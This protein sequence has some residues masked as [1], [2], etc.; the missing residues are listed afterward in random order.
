[1][2]REIKQKNKIDN[3]VQK[4]LGFVKSYYRIIGKKYGWHQFLGSNKIGNI[5]TAQA[6]L[7]FHYFQKDFSE[8]HRAITSIKQAQ[9]LN[10]NDKTLDGGWANVTNAST[11]PTT[12]CSGWILLL[13]LEE[14]INAGECL[15]KGIA[16][17]LANHPTEEKSDLGWSSI[18]YDES[19]LKYDEIRVYATALA[20]RVL[21]R[22][23]YT[24]TDQFIKA[25]HWLIMARNEQDGGWGE[26]KGSPSTFLHTAHAL[27]ALRECGIDPD[28]ETLSKGCDWLLNM[29]DPRNLWNDPI[30][31]GLMEYV[32]IY[33]P[34]IQRVTYLHFT[35]PWV[36]N[37][38]IMCGRINTIQVFRGINWIVENCHNGYWD[39]PY[40][41]SSKNKPMW[42]IYDSLLALKNFQ[43][44]FSHWSKIKQV[45]L[46]NG[47]ITIKPISKT[48]ISITQYFERLLKSK[49]TWVCVGVIL[50]VLFLIVFG[51]LPAREGILGVLVPFLIAI[52]ANLVTKESK[53]GKL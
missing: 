50:V 14:K 41:V 30:R 42:A 25:K 32:D 4:A 17:L 3:V 33:A 39:H 18:K 45:I 51:I 35:T 12:E 48:R 15:N 19:H 47:E 29:Y 44:T 53:S 27:I 37:A 34:P 31:G 2:S 52:V 11:F 23:K 36:I 28:S 13:L 6:L 8:K 21:A 1:M 43:A 40:L 5:A 46:K 7:C 49:I 38:L 10:K 20:L 9:F 22:G 24:T 26:K 16:W